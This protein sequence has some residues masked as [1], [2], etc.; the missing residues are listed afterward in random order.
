MPEAAKALRLLTATIFRADPLRA[1]AAIVLE[2]SG[3]LGYILLPIGLKMLADGVVQSDAPLLLSAAAAMAALQAIHWLGQ[4]FGTRL[5]LTLLERVGFAFDREVTELTANL[6]GIE[7]HERPEYQDRLQ[8]LREAQ[9][10]LGNGANDLVNFLNYGVARTAGALAVLASV[11]P[12]LA[13]L[14]LFGLPLVWTEARSQRRLARADEESTGLRRLARHLH[15]LCLHAGPGKELRIFGLQ[16]EVP[17][18]QRVAWLSAE[19][20]RLSS[21]WRSSVERAASWL[22]FGLGFA[23]AVMYAANLAL[24]GLASAG[25]VLLTVA[26][27]AQ[28]TGHVQTAVLALAAL[29]QAVRDTSRLVWLRDY[30]VHERSSIGHVR[31]P[32][33]LRRGLNLEGVS[34]RYPGSDAW[35]IREASVFLP[36]GSVVA[37]VG[38]NGAGKTT[39]VKLL[40]RFY[41]PTEGRVTV[42]DADLS[43]LDP[44]RWRE[45]VSA[46]FQ[47]FY[48]FQLIAREVVGVGDLPRINDESAVLGALDRAGGADVPSALP[49]GLRSQLGREWEG[50]VDLSEGQW[51]KLALGRSMMREAPLLLLLDEPTASL[52]APTEHKLFERFAEASHR[53]S[54]TNGAVTVLVSHRFSTVRMANLIVVLEHG[55]ILEV[56][57]HDELMRRRALYA[58]LFELQSRAYA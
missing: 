31:P 39:L 41:L 55:R 17:A 20:V 40:A 35:A 2:V 26:L 7:H 1:T 3:G 48:R 13:A 23:G 16:D 5:R 46:G 28:V 44:E 24:R 58:E 30:A 54:A 57:S 42:D 47:D 21:R 52:D 19:G 36:T 51:Q 29:G 50:G 45:R 9:G 14:P 11:H 43:E 22:I 8:L 49:I 37:L 56:G 12:L 25:D 27:A 4:G 15:E 18:R 38:E 32:D 33:R 53:V 6:P 10:A 34:F